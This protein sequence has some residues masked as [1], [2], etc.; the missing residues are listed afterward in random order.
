MSSR[1]KTGISIVMVDFFKVAYDT[2]LSV[3]YVG[4]CVSFPKFN[5]VP[6]IIAH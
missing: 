1:Q 3:Y 4:S 2:R 6:F 5:L